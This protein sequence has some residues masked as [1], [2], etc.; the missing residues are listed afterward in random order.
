MFGLHV[1]AGLH[2]GEAG[3][4]AGPTLASADEWMLVVQGRQTH[5]ARPRDG[6]D[7]ITVGTQS[8][9]ARQVNIAATPVVPTAGR[10]N[11]GVRLNI[12]P[13]RATLVG[14]LRSFD[15]EVRR[16]VIARFGRIAADFARAA[17]AEAT[18]GVVNTAP[19]TVND[20]APA[21]RVLPSLQAAV[22]AGHVGEMPLQTVAEDFAQFADAVPGAYFFVG[23]TPADKDPAAKP[24][25]HS[26]LYARDEAALDVGLKT[27]LQVATDYLDPPAGANAD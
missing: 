23:T 19:A 21:R 2:V 25:N 6:V 8:M 5:G 9:L 24:I 20:P 16:D 11:A 4:R 13:D 22:G 27:M 7:P 26:L 17:G 14:T 10:F 3:F 1:W 18:L 12:I 15:P